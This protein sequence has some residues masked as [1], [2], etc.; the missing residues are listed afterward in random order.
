MT[1]MMM[2]TII[3]TEMSDMISMDLE[4]IL[5]INNILGILQNGLIL[6]LILF[7]VMKMIILSYL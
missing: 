3:T 2:M 1:M 6:I 5:Q 7:M 4:S